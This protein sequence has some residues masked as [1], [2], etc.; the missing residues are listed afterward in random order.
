[1]TDRGRAVAVLVPIRGDR[2]QELVTRGQIL[3]AE[4]DGTVLDE[5]PVDYGIE[6]STRLAEIR[7][8]EG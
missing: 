5:A 4:G 1:M 8:E 7:A 6:A 3:R 2:W